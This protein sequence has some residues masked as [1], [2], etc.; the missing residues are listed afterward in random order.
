MKTQRLNDNERR[1]WVLNDESLYGWMM[2][3]GLGVKAFIAKY[4]TEID[5][6]ILRMLNAKPAEKTWRDYV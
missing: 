3:E 2:G 1:L 5:E 6:A 4:R